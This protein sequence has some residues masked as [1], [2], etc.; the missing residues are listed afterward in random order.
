M[1]ERHH[2]AVKKSDL[3]SPKQYVE[4]GDLRGSEQVALHEPADVPNVRRLHRI[5]QIWRPEDYPGLK[6]KRCD[7][8]GYTV[9]RDAGVVAPGIVFARDGRFVID[10]ATRLGKMRLSRRVE[11]DLRSGADERSDWPTAATLDRGILVS[12][13]GLRTYGHALLDF[14]PGVAML[15][16]QKAFDGW[17]L[18]L[19]DNRPDWLARMV[20]A[21]CSSPREIVLFSNRQHDVTRVKRLCVPWVVRGPGFH[22]SAREVFTQISERAAPDQA[23]TRRIFAARDPELEKRRLTNSAEIEAVLESRG[24]ESVRPE[25]LPFLEQVRLFASAE[26]AAGE[27]GSGLH[28]TIFSPPGTKTLELRPATYD[29]P[30]QPAIAVLMGHWFASVQGPQAGSHRMSHE[31]WTLDPELVERRLTEL[32]A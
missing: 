24:F 2:T 13:P 3:W 31:P 30:G 26:I 16:R 10:D 23:A 11:E 14:L 9:I 32:G 4:A 27:A 21:F 22:P 19:P 20:E 29:A 12:R 18:L 15:D 6:T 1:P 5:D 17:P 8:P 7:S 28:G 25:R